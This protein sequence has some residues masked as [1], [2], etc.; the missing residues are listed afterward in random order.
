M[1]HGAD[2]RKDGQLSEFAITGFSFSNVRGYGTHG[3]LPASWLDAQ[4]ISFTIVTTEE[5]ADKILAWAERD[6]IA[7][8]PGIAYV[9]DVVAVGRT[10]STR[11]T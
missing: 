11:R 6:L 9:T 7:H 4:N 1:V 3:S 2:S 8:H 10:L 5:L